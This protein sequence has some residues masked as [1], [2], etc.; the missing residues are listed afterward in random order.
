MTANTDRFPAK[1]GSLRIYAGNFVA[2]SN[3]LESTAIDIVLKFARRNVRGLK[4]GRHYLSRPAWALF[5]PRSQRLSSGRSCRKTASPAATGA[6]SS[7][8]VANRGLPARSSS[9]QQTFAAS[10]GPI[11]LIS[12]PVRRSWIYSSSSN[13][14]TPAPTSGRRLVPS[15]ARR[16]WMYRSSWNYQTPAPTSGGRLVPSPAR[17]SWMYR[18]ST[19]CQTPAATS[20][21]HLVPSPAR[22][23]PW[24]WRCRP[25]PR[26]C[27]R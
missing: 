7:R 15:P 8:A 17:R 23:D 3:S 22:W 6:R 19:I 5:N 2:R 9:N 27:R 14:R 21:G 4:G 1:M 18:P 10:S 13:Y 16:S 26:K 20:G 24:S 12:I 11:L 25:C